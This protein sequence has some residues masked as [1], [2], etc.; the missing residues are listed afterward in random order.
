MYK[1]LRKKVASTVNDI[2]EPD[3]FEWSKWLRPP[4]NEELPIDRFYSYIKN[5]DNL[6]LELTPPSSEKIEIEKIPTELLDNK[7]QKHFFVNKVKTNKVFFRLRS[8]PVNK[9]QL[10]NRN[11]FKILFSAGLRQKNEEMLVSDKEGELNSKTKFHEID[12]SLKNDV[13]SIQ[14]PTV[15]NPTD[16]KI[17]SPDISNYLDSTASTEI[18]NIELLNIFSE[19]LDIENFTLLTKTPDII[20]IDVSDVKKLLEEL[21]N[22]KIDVEIKNVKI[23]YLNSYPQVIKVKT[24]SLNTIKVP[25]YYL[26][27]VN[28]NKTKISM[29][30]FEDLQRAGTFK[31][32]LLH[33]EMTAPFEETDNEPVTGN[34]S[35]SDN[36]DVLL[37]ENK[38]I[39]NFNEQAYEK[40]STETVE[41]DIDSSTLLNF[42]KKGVKFLT[43][44]KICLLN[45][46]PGI[47]KPIQVIHALKALVENN[48]VKSFLIISSKEQ[49][50]DKLISQ[51]MNKPIGWEGYLTYYLPHKSFIYVNG[52]AALRKRMWANE[53]TCL[54]T[55]YENFFT[56]VKSNLVN[57]EILKKFDCLIFDNAEIIFKNSSRVSDL[58]RTSQAK[59]VWYL[60]NLPDKFLVDDIESIYKK[61]DS[62][63]SFRRSKE[64]LS[65]TVPEVIRRE[66]WLE[67]DE[68][69]RIEYDNVLNLGKDKILKLLEAGNPFI[70]QSNIYTLIHQLKQIC[71]FAASKNSSPKSNFLVN[72]IE[73]HITSNKKIIIAS[74]YD[75]S[76]INKI[77]ELFKENGIKYVS[78][79][80]GMSINEVEKAKLHFKKDNKIHVLINGLKSSR[81]A[82]DLG[83]VGYFI[84]F[85]QWWNPSTVWKTEDCVSKP[86]DESYRAKENLVIYEYL[87]KGTFEE[88]LRELL[89]RKGLI[90]KDIIELISADTINQIVTVD[91]WLQILGIKNNENKNKSF[92]VDRLKTLSTKDLSHKIEILF[93]RLGYKNIYLEKGK[94]ENEYDII[95]TMVTESKKLKISGKCLLSSDF[96]TDDIIEEI[97][98]L[99]LDKISEKNFLI[100]LND[101]SENILSYLK[102]SIIVINKNLLANYLAD[103]LLL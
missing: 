5:I 41:I 74:Q 14:L 24:I 64:D 94:R 86:N 58:I 103:F 101:S 56:D 65:G 2:E 82:T 102:P 80:N 37:N 29:N 59:Y 25:T 15:N 99:E 53:S 22:Q 50:G 42:Q 75:K 46:D 62:V 73:Q 12:I 20:H 70:I 98:N 68:E 100:H 34:E 38:L 87:T 78:C 48:I 28:L 17:M 71:N 76:G 30:L 90:N 77:E 93:N 27:N 18:T 19:K 11:N 16:L 92:L 79:S 8:I 21:Y 33:Y 67:L 63:P 61:K 89:N 47:D 40:T 6:N 95:G 81:T 83:E 57:N 26:R 51:K 88:D 55:T 1:I 66:I 69:Q 43:Q 60:S 4:T 72:H 45:D 52:D 13:Y 96:T 97:T 9:I 91:E 49:I 23:D 44:N 10:P 35:D 7:Y 39:E 3:Q 32:E 31:K 36:I 84:H 85:D 54:M